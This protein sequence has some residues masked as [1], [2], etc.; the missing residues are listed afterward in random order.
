[1]RTNFSSQPSGLA[2]IAMGSNLGRSQ[3]VLSDTMERLQEFS[4]GTLLRSSLWQSTPVDCPPGSPLFVNA[5]VG[6]NPRADETPELLLAKLQQLEKEFGR[7]NKTVLNEPRPLDLDLIAF[8]NETRSTEKLI[9][10]HPRAQLRRFVL[11]PLSE[12]APDLI[13]PGQSQSVAELLAGLTS[14]EVVRK[15]E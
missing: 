4:T 10:P 6:L 11:Q 1:M 9:L 5:V 7:K 12:I 14:D 8:G 13:L 3:Q 15:L 2:Y